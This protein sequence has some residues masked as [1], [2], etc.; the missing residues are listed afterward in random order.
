MVAGLDN[1][2]NDAL[3][4]VETEI[5]QLIKTLQESLHHVKKLRE[6]P[7]MNKLA[8]PN[9]G[10]E[11][12]NPTD[13][14]RHDTITILVERWCN[15]CGKNREICACGSKSDDWDL[16]SMPGNAFYCSWCGDAF[17]N[18]DASEEGDELQC[19]C[20]KAI[21]QGYFLPWGFGTRPCP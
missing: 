13:P 10:R 5:E 21:A 6:N 4:A 16:G 9:R 15:H 12:T 19:S 14:T 11:A 20:T 7:D 18:N 17:A 1:D 8:A 2:P 3:R